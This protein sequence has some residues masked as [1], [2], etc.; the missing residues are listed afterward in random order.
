MISAEQVRKMRVESAAKAA[1]AEAA[2]REAEAARQAKLRENI[3]RNLA[4]IEKTIVDAATTKTSI[5][6]EYSQYD[7]PAQHEVIDGVLA[8]LKAAG[9]EIMA[10]TITHTLGFGDIPLLSVTNLEVTISW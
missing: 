10:Q 1:A 6:I 7:I 3:E 2:G 5:V 9:Y 8:G 4:R